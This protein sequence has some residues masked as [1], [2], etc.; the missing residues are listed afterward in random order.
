MPK[1]SEQKQ[2]KI[3]EAVLLFLFQSSPKA[4]FTSHVSQELARDEEYMKKLLLELEQKNI[5]V[6]VKKNQDGLDFKKRMRWR[7]SEQAYNAYKAAQGQ[8]QSQG[9]GQGLQ[10]QL[11]AAQQQ[12]EQIEQQIE[13]PPAPPEPTPQQPSISGEQHSTEQPASSAQQDTQQAQPSSS[14]SSSE[15]SE[16][17]P[18]STP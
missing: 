18:S 14:S 13:I 1:I 2:E 11:H 8:G 12:I 7:L 10:I 9:Q 15:T 5:V 16:T 17:N 4:L 3:K 6:S